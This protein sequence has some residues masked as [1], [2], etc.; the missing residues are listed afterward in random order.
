MAKN[1]FLYSLLAFWAAIACSQLDDDVD[2]SATVQL[3]VSTDTLLFD[4]LLTSRTSLTKRM[5]I[6]NPEKNAVNIERIALAGGES[7]PYG[8]IV[9]GKAG[10][11]ENEFLAAGD[12]LLVLV[13]VT[14]D[15][16]NTN[17]PFL[18]KDSLLISWN[19]NQQDIKLIAWG[20]EANY[21]MG[22]IVCDETW[23]AD[24]PYVIQQA[25]LVDSLCTLTIE[26]GT[27]VYIDN[28]A[29][30]FV[31]GQLKVSGDSG[32]HVVFR[33]TRFDED[34]IEAPGQWGGLVFFPGSRENVLS[35]ATI[36]N[37]QN[38]IF[39]FGSS[40]TSD[41]VEISIDH[42]VIRH[43]SIAGIQTFTSEVQMS[44]SLIYNCGAYL[45]GNFVGGN[46]DYSYC[47]FSNEP[48]FF[49]RD[50]PSLIFLDN[51]PGEVG[52]VDDLILSVTNSIL[53][54]TERDEL[55]IGND[56]GGLLDTTF[57]NNIVKFS[58]DL[59]GNF[60]S[61]QTNFPGFV[62]PFLFNF[63]LDSL[64]FARDKGNTPIFDDLLGIP[65]DEMP[66]LGALERVDMP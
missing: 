48:S 46:Y 33:N 30:I 28:G 29:S 19:G 1:I 14:I 42:S 37:A 47:T 35:Y 26:A 45:V 60:T 52:L 39:A 5:R 15:P 65:R 66:D 44:N 49:I 4:T 23:T 54:G 32:N 53:W 41:R 38:G 63:A 21:L 25:L 58:I 8:L 2:N 43:M 12:S 24:K 18:V 9:N 40:N 22:A 36:E 7:S 50:D 56:G 10:A 27:R 55:L 3:T 11:I 57:Q 6:F 17:D 51:L 61:Q 16:M 64:S 31:Q 59:I 62:D 34:F 13:D 20:Q